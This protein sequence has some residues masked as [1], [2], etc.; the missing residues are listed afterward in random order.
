MKSIKYLALAAIIVLTANIRAWARPTVTEIMNKLDDL[1]FIASDISAK[2]KLTQQKAGQG[3]KEFEL[4]YYR[5]DTDDAFLIV[6]TSP[7][8][9]AGNGYLRVGDNFWMYRQNTRTFQHINR[10]DSIAG[11]DYQSGNFETGK[12]VELYQPAVDA[13]GNE[14]ISEEMLGDI[15]VYRIELVAKVNDVTYPKQIY[16]VRRDNFLPLKQQSF[17]LSGT[18]MLTGYFLKYTTVQGHYVCIKSMMID[19]FEQGNKTIMEITGIAFSPIPDSYF[20]KAYLENLS[21]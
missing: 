2:I 20:T 11:T 4:L 12:L 5:R 13:N 8:A 9:E 14:L 19:E 7:S 3:V 17:S 18:L 10:D 21:R 16:W 1:Q 15:P 6:M